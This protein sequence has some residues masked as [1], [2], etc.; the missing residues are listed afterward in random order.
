MLTTTG[1]FTLYNLQLHVLDLYSYEQEIDLADND[2]FQVVPETN[3]ISTQC[4]S[5]TLLK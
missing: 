3:T 4:S 1:S 5:L 2:V